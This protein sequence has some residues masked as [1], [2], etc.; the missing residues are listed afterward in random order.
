MSKQ[1]SA[2][3]KAAD[4]V[5]LLYRMGQLIDPRT[6]RLVS[7]RNPGRAIEL[8]KAALDRATARRAR[9]K[10]GATRTSANG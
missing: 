1:N 8:A 9:R 3:R 10:S 4:R 2:E 5:F 6:G 7:L